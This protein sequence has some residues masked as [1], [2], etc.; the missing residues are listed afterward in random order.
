MDLADLARMLCFKGFWKMA[1]RHW[2]MG[3]EEIHRSL[4]KPA[5][6]RSVQ[7]LV[8]AIRAEDLLPAGS[9]VRAQAVS[10][11]GD[12]LD[13]F[14]LVQRGRALHLCNAPSPAATASL[15]IGEHITELARKQFDL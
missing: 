7:R 12:L 14:H 13:D 2:K 11:E 8:P 5:F 1:R 6:V 4:V 9:G 3:L 15:A 10:M